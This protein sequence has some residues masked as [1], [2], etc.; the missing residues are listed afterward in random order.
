MEAGERLDQILAATADLVGIRGFW[1]FTLRDVA[2]SC[3]ITEAGI[4]HHVKSKAGLLVATLERRDEL[5][6]ISLANLLGITLEN[7]DDDPLPFGLRDM[8]RAL[9]LRNSTQ[10][11]MV[12]LYSVMLSE[13]LDPDHPAHDFYRE[14]EQW[15]MDFFERAAA[16][17]GIEDTR[18]IALQVFSAMD[19][20]QLRWLRDPSG[21]NLQE[22]WEKIVG[23][24]LPE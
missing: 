20:L 17:D 16:T 3:G 19:G 13:S 8:S 9:V 7:L 5:D 22:E 21:V 4:L 10:P 1:G 2:I 6:M 12:R 23:V 15:V 11:E 18:T 14:R 24:L